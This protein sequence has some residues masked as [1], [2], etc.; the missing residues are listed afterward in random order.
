MYMA[1]RSVSNFVTD[2]IFFLSS[3]VITGGIETGYYSQKVSMASRSYK[4]TGSFI[5]LSVVGGLLCHQLSLYVDL[6]VF[7]SLYAACS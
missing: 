3:L 4:L 1:S 7:V 2:A 6:S 5:Y